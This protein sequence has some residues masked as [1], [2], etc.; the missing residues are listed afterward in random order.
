VLLD[1]S[2]PDAQGLDGLRRLRAAA[3]EV[4]VVVLSGLHDEQV[5][6]HAVQA[7]AQD[8]LMKGEVES[9]TLAR[10]MRY[11]VERQR[12]ERRLARMAL[13][14]PLTGLPNRVLFADRLEQALARRARGEQPLRLALMFID[15]NDFKAVNDRYGHLAGDELLVEVGH[16]LRAELRGSDTVAR[17]GGDEFTVLCEGVTD[18]ADAMALARRIAISLGCPYALAAGKVEISAA[19]GVTLAAPTGEDPATLLRRAD[20]AMYEAK[21][22]GPGISILSEDRG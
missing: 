20:A 21:A 9:S 5:A 6:L 14:D 19:V 16:R 15:L 17:L 8:Y 4:P 7:G 12:A 13:R 3:P 2:L 10:A 22:A 18:P 1:L 11:A